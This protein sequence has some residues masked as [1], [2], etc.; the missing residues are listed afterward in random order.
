MI[1]ILERG[2]DFSSNVPIFFRITT[3]R[4]FFGEWI[5]LL[6]QAYFQGFT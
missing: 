3:V 5:H 4:S 1:E 2:G 6:W